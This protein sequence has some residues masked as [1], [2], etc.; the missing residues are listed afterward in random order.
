[1]SWTTTWKRKGVK[2][3]SATVVS[4]YHGY[5]WQNALKDDY[6][7]S[8]VPR[9]SLFSEWAER[10]ESHLLRKKEMARDEAFLGGH[11][12]GNFKRSREISNDPEKPLV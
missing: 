10:E 9:R 8:I 2:I 6:S 5:L 7:A 4:S 1:M 3:A 11:F 12:T